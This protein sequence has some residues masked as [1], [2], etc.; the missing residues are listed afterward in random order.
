M[1]NFLVNFFKSQSSFFRD[2]KF[3]NVLSEKKVAKMETLLQN[4]EKV[5]NVTV[6]CQDGLLS[7]HKLVLAGLSDFIKNILSEIPVGD[8][9]T[10]LMPDF[11]AEEVEK[12]L[13]AS[14]KETF[15]E[16]DVDM[17]TAFGIKTHTLFVPVD[18]QLESEHSNIKSELLLE[19]DLKTEI[20]TIDNEPEYNENSFNLKDVCPKKKRKIYRAKR[21]DIKTVDV[22]DKIRRLQEQIIINP[23]TELDIKKN[24]KILISLKFQRAILEVITTGC[25]VSRTANRHKVSRST[26]RDLLK[27]GRD[28]G[29]LGG[30]RVR[31]YFTDEEEKIICK[32]ALE[33]CNGGV[34]L[35][36][37]IFMEIV[38]E[39]ASNI[40]GNEPDR[41]FKEISES[42]VRFLAKK[43]NLWK[44]YK[45]KRE[46]VRDGY[47]YE[48]DICFQKYSTHKGMLNHKKCV[49]FPF[50]NQHIKA[51][52]NG[53]ALKTN[54]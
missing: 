1:I 22:K 17:L 15:S 33:Q 5:S 14:L 42:Y 39:E 45:E 27:S 13:S 34:N 36:L 21:A 25:S 31:K 41:E 18:T 9:V 32:R 6:R 46:A 50:L 16:K 38:N 28:W 19:T 52:K 53:R 29:G 47:E 11:R 40:K 37:K 51:V 54:K 23:S 30:C 20:D 44:H 43:L 4:C 48:C 12:F 3:V 49:H 26:L 35:T 2:K 10:L 8:E 24:E 7:S